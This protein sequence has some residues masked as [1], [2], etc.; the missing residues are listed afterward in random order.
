MARKSKPRLVENSFGPD[1]IRPEVH[2]FSEGIFF[3]LRDKNRIRSWLNKVAARHKKAIGPL[4]YIFVSDKYLLQ[5]NRRHLDHDTLT[6]II[7]FDYSQKNIVSGDIY[8]SVERVNENAATYKTMRRDELHRVMAHGLL[9]LCGFGDKS[10]RE[11]TRMRAEE[12]K[13]LDLRQF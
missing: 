13:A 12:E 4:T 5:L 9:H 8:I 6:D 3:T 10:E 11:A 2:F 1:L 7:T